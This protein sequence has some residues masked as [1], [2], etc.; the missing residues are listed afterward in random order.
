MRET[1]GGV[2]VGRIV[3]IGLQNYNEIIEKNCF[4]VDKTYFIKDWWESNDSTT[5]ITRPRRFGKTLTMSMVEQFFSVCYAERSDLFENLAIW[6]Y[7]D[8]QKLQGT[9]PV[10]SLSFA[11]VKEKNYKNALERILQILQ[12]IYVQNRFLLCCGVLE[13]FEQEYFQRMMSQMSEID[14]AQAIPNLCDFLY[15]YYK[16]KVIVLLD[17]YDTPMQEAYVGGFWEELTDFTRSFFNA[18]FKTNQWLERALMTGITRVSKESIFSDLNHLEVITTTTEKYETVFGFTEEEVFAA[19]DEFGLQEK[20]QVKQWYDGFV[21]G[22]KRGIYNPW[23]ILNYLDKRKFGTYWA[24]TSS[25]NLVSKLIREGSPDVKITMEDL[26]KGKVLHTQIDEQIVYHQLGMDATSIWSLLVASGYFKVE[27]YE[28][29]MENGKGEYDLSLTNME[30]RFMFQ[31]MIGHWFADFVPYAYN[32]FVKALLLGDVKA[33]NT[34]MNR[35][36]LK[37][38]SYFDTGKEPS[39]WEPERFY[40]GFVLGLMIELNG[41]YAIFSNRESGFG[42]YDVMLEPFQKEDFAYILE[43]KVHDSEDEKTL[44]DTVAAA[45]AQIE[46]KR[47]E[48]NLMAK[49]ISR[50]KIRKYGFAFQGKQVL[51]G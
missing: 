10:I 36:A 46:E 5:L 26:L 17:E 41:R 12:K 25:N 21:F 48:E 6:K 40:H 13:A 8:Y 18:S 34:Y 31:N 14:A 44:K 19:M 9:Y 4:Y 42:R 29:N 2:F 1:N 37:T 11:S 27:K 3:A 23:S 15:R 35:V 51:I 32:S 43:F 16:K 7:E 24:N 49:G 39:E 28:F 20:K 33:M 50:E 38:F 47:Y 30:V 22:G 45:L